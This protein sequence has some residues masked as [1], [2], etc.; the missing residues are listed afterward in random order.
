MKIKN[1]RKT[2]DFLALESWDSFIKFINMHKQELKGCIYRGQ[3]DPAWDLKPSF[4]REKPKEYTWEILQNLALNTQLENFKKFTRG[5]HR[6]SYTD[7]NDSDENWWSLGQ[8]YGLETP[9][10]D[11][12]RSPFVA[13]FF[14]FIDEA[15]EQSRAIFILDIEGM[16][17][18]LDSYR[19]EAP[20][21]NFIKMIDPLTHENE[22]LVSQQGVFTYI[23]HYRF[24][25]IEDYL[26]E[27][28]IKCKD[29]I[30]GELFL[31]KLTIPSHERLRILDQLNLM[32][33]D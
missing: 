14:S 12:V 2:E 8:H 32:K 9:L 6:I 17:Q 11:W 23:N 10:L 31:L 29:K 33:A 20:I 27:F 13:T 19:G 28:K 3:R 24:R 18:I 1:G 16:K 7:P 4:F 30:N 22:R 26:N 21:Q 15:K 25:S 5:R